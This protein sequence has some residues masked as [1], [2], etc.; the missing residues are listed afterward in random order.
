MKAKL[1]KLIL[2]HAMKVRAS[3]LR[4]VKSFTDLAKASSPLHQGP[5]GTIRQ[6]LAKVI[7]KE[8]G[9]DMPLKLK[10][11]KVTKIIESIIEAGE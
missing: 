10:D 1:I 6:R 4:G 8:L 2:Q 3:Q 11:P 9:K 5:I 7:I